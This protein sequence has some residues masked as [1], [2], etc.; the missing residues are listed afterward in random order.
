MIRVFNQYK[1]LWLLL[2]GMVLVAVSLW[3]Y[4]TKFTLL[5]P[6]AIS[7][8]N[9]GIIFYVLTTKYFKHIVY[10]IY[11]SYHLI[12]MILPI[13]L[14]VLFYSADEI[15]Y[16]LGNMLNIDDDDLVKSNLM[17]LVYD[18]MV[19]IA[20]VFYNKIGLIKQKSK[21]IFKYYLYNSDKYFFIILIALIAY[22]MKI[23]LMSIGA[24]FM[25]EDVDLSGYALAN[26]AEV[27]QKLDI[28]ILLFF[29]Y[30][31]RYDKSKKFLILMLIIAIISIVFAV[32][33]TSKEKLF[34]V[35][36]PIALLLLQSKYK[37]T[38]FT[39]M[40]ILF[41]NSGILFEYFMYL[42]IHNNNSV[43]DNTIEFTQGK[44]IQNE[45]QDILDNKL[46]QRLGYQFKVSKAIKVYDTPNF[47]IKSDYLYN[48]YGLIPRVF[49]PDKPKIISGNQFGHD[50]GLIH[51]ND[52][53]TSVGITPVGE[54]FYE[55]GYLGI[56]VVPLFLALLLYAFSKWF[57]EHTWIGF[58]MAI[59]MGLE[60]GMND[61]YSP[62]IP[63]LIK[64]LLVFYIIGL[65]L[66]KKYTDEI[67][68]K[69][70]FK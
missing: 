43:I 10:K 19:I 14:V 13:I 59:M 25:Y 55:L 33:S 3:L 21:T 70:K 46:L 29:V 9:L 8:L 5:L 56:F 28:L 35:L 12:T 66:S 64:P 37:K 61:K 42:R 15:N 26:T 44:K 41:V 18:L 51:R 23:Y 47:E 24:W 38:Y 67:K 40:F 69:I 36:I 16:F 20:I 11:Y 7:I 58:L 32:L 4:A 57:N 39:L 31:Y 50:L 45:H 53:V 60:L 1:N 62:L 2:A 54:A 65:I 6:T 17:I 48:I 22:S 34:L 52:T 30:N 49:W 27:L 68:L 63:G